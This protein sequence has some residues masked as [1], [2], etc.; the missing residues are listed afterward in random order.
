MSG[1]EAKLTVCTPLQY[2][3][4]VFGMV[5]FAF[6]ELDG[7]GMAEQADVVAS[8]EKRLAEIAQRISI[9]L[10]TVELRVK[11][12]H[13]ALTDALT[14]LC[15]R[16]AFEQ[17][18]RRSMAREQRHGLPYAFGILDID[19]F[20]KVNDGFGHDVGDALLQQ[21]SELLRAATR[22]TDTVGRLGG[23]EF[24]ILLE[25]VNPEEAAQKFEHLRATIEAEASAGDRR[26][27]AS[28]RAS[29]SSYSKGFP[30]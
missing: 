2:H 7:L 4:R 11:L 17:A 6:D 21:L 22:R 14:G 30:R 19:L 8:R 3:D 28:R 15:N 26:I 9:A 1:D 29:S 20:K 18:V 23:E 25:G 27:T 12:E 16:R 10:A 13:A 5:T 24:G